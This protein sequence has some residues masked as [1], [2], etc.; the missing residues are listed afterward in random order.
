MA[1]SHTINVDA[2]LAKD[3]IKNFTQFRTNLKNNLV[4]PNVISVHNLEDYA[5][6]FMSNFTNVSSAESQKLLLNKFMKAAQTSDHGLS[7]FIQDQC[8]CG[9]K[10][11]VLID[12]LL[13]K[14]SNILLNN[15][16]KA[17]N[18]NM[19]MLKCESKK[20]KLQT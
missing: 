15:Y 13:S 5:V 4:V 19:V 1:L 12:R 8:T 11:E 14:F 7:S 16:S 17:R 2:F 6:F 3:V 20:R 9:V 18:N 10:R